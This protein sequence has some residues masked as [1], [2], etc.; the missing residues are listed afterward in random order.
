MWYLIGGLAL[1]YGAAAAAFFIGFNRRM[2]L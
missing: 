2:S 1:V